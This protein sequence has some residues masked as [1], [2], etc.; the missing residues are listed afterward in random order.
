MRWDNS[1]TTHEATLHRNREFI[2]LFRDVVDAHHGEFLFCLYINTGTFRGLETHGGKG[3]HTK[4]VLVAKNRG[5]FT[6]TPPEKTLVLDYMGVGL[7]LRNFIFNFQSKRWSNIKHAK[8]CYE[9]WT[10]TISRKKMENCLADVEKQLPKTHKY[11]KLIGVP[12]HLQL[13]GSTSQTD[14]LA[15]LRSLRIKGVGGIPGEH[16]GQNCTTYSLKFARKAGFHFML[17]RLFG[18]NPK[19][20]HYTLALRKRITNWKVWYRG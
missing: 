6:K 15:K 20:L 17:E 7:S 1:T 11:E 9:L 12:R 2:E 14:I 18:S 3:S 5:D 19:N 4:V 13:R 10:N 8:N 16:W